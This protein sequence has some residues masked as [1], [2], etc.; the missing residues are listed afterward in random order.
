MGAHFHNYLG[1]S[2]GEELRLGFPTVPE[3]G[4]AFPPTDGD[5]TVMWLFLIYFYFA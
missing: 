1:S 2:A 3:K 4:A 5:E